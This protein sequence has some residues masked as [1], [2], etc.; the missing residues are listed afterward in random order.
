MGWDQWYQADDATSN[1][2]IAAS[3]AQHRST[4][5]ETS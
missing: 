1:E 2:Q 3:D 4:V 5:G